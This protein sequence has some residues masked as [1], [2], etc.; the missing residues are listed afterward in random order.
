MGAIVLAHGGSS[1]FVAICGYHD[2]GR[3][4]R[5][6]LR[7]PSASIFIGNMLLSI[8]LVPLP[9]TFRFASCFFHLTIRAQVAI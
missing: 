2:E 4:F 6:F 5:A 1:A 9:V 3:P 8:G 7:H